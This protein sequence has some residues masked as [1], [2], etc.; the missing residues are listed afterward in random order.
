MRGTVLEKEVEIFCYKQ[1]TKPS[2]RISLQRNGKILWRHIVS[3]TSTTCGVK[4][5]H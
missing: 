4:P 3:T 2:A 1:P 5:E